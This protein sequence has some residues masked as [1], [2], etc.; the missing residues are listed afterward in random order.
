M[1]SNLQGRS[2]PDDIAADG[3]PR[4]YLR[5][6]GRRD[7]TEFLGLMQESRTLHEPWI[8]PPLTPLAFQNYLAR[9][10]RDDHE[11]LLVCIRDTDAI[12]GVINLNNI[13]RGTFLSASLGY[14]AASRYA[15][16]GYMQEGLELVKTHAFRSLGLH[17]LE[18]NIQ[19]DNQRSIA[20]VRRCGFVKEGISHAFLYL[21]GRW[22]DHERWAV[23]DPRPTLNP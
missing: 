18:A 8:S 11:G 2:P 6:V 10:Q 1:S 20:L 13:V 9:T 21:A 4:V 5:P 16:R 3:P 15:G 19:P 17:R 12:T 23:Y 7:R 22:R 14:Y